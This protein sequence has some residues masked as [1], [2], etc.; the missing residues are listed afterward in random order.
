[1]SAFVVVSP[2][3]LLNPWLP[4][5]AVR[6]GEMGVLDLGYKP[7]ADDHRNAIEELVRH[8]A[9][10]DRWGIRWD[11]L[12]DR[13][14]SPVVLKELLFDLECP[15]LILAGAS[16]AGV[17]LAELRDQARSLA[18]KVFLEA[19]SAKDAEAAAEAG[20]DGVILKGHESSGRVADESAYLLL[21]RARQRWSIP[22]WV[23][24]GLGPDTAAAAFL[25][26][27]A[28][29]VLGEQLWLAAESPFDSA[30]RQ[31]WALADGSETVVIGDDAASFRFYSQTG[32][33]VRAEL[34]RAIAQQNDWQAQLRDYL[35]TREPAAAA[36]LI[37][38]GQE[39]AFA[40]RLAEKH[41]NVAGIL[42]AYR[43]RIDENLARAKRGRALEPAGPL[44]EAIGTRYPIF[45]APLAGITDVPEFSQAVA[46]AGA[47]PCLAPGLANADQTRQLLE[48]T[49]E[50]VNGQ[51]WGVGVVGYAP[52]ELQAQQLKVIAE[53]KPRFVILGPGGA[54]VALQLENQGIH[55]FL[56]AA[57]PGALELL[58]RHGARRFVFAGSECGT[59]AGPRTSFTLWQQMI[60][61]LLDSQIGKPEECQL[62]F[63]GGIHDGLTAAMAAALAAPLAALGM[64]IGVMV[65]TGYLFTHE[66]VE[67]GAITEEFQGQ[68]IACEGT[69][70]LETGPGY[71]TRCARTAFAEE[72][73]RF[74]RDLTAQGKT[75]DELHTELELFKLA[76]LRLAS[77]GPSH[78]TQPH[79]GQGDV[80][81]G[82]ANE[83][84]MYLLGQAAALRDEPFWN[85]WRRGDCPGSEG[86]KS[87]VA[88]RTI[89][90]WWAC[91]ACS[92][93]PT[94]CASTGGTYFRASM[95]SRRC[96]PIAGG[97][98]T[99]I[100]RTASRGTAST[101]SGAAF[102]AKSSS[103]R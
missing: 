17:M 59:C 3:H 32:N 72:F 76:R 65:G 103:T 33:D 62:L 83:G 96:P 25:A 42:Q 36:E 51:A 5:A 49:R 6:A 41:V 50:L 73:H 15:T 102:S 81:L 47:V 66:A 75:N 74:K 10:L 16:G 60:D 68:A 11:L 46:A 79:Q 39:I 23:Q 77:K 53:V 24:G 63:A 84:G 26:D 95:P 8:T 4:I 1:L 21:A 89:L 87:I 56:H 98:T 94:T 85:D 9:G 14:R 54:E 28:G 82:S 92:P 88:N 18:A 58:L 101:P 78:V 44:A 93:R 70:L 29:I 99:T 38:L 20:F 2:S 86:P 45:Q 67:C 43:S 37:P 61:V 22:F 31:R 80:K 55:A 100:R 97:P 69:V 7:L 30:A 71:A 52:P 48:E 57:A 35:A 13:A 12:A 27:A 34:A 64:K 19:Y 40:R 90:R 91:R